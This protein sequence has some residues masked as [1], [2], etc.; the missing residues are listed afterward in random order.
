M[1]RLRLSRD[2][3]A[4]TKSRSNL[5][6][7]EKEAVARLLSPGNG[8]STVTAPV[9]AFPMPFL[10]A[11]LDNPGL[12]PNQRAVVAIQVYGMSGNGTDHDR[13]YQTPVAS[14]AE[15]GAA[16][17]ALGSRHPNCEMFINGRFYPVALGIQFFGDPEEPAS[18]KGILL[19]GVLS[20]CE[21]TFSISRYVSPDLFLDEAGQP[22]ERTV[23]DILDQFGFRRLQTSPAE[24]NVKL[25]RAERAAREVGRVVVVSGPVISSAS[26]WW[27]GFE[28]QS[29]TPPGQPRKGV[30]EPELEVSDEE[31]SYL[32]PFGR[33]R[34]GVT[35]LPFV[36][37]FCLDTKSYVYADV[38]DVTTH[39]F[40]KE[41][42]SRLHLPEETRWVLT[43][44]FATP[45]ESLFG[46]LIRG[47]HGGVVVLACGRPGVGKTLTAEVYAE[48]TGR[49]L[50]VLEMGELGTNVAQVE[51]NLRR[52]FTRVARWGAVLQL[53][54]AEIFLTERGE[55]LERS[56]I[57]GCFLRLLDYYS[58]LL[59]LSTNR[60]E[61]LDRAVLSR[62]ILKINYPDLDQR[63]RA[64]IWRTMLASAGFILTGGTVEEL[65]EAPLNGRQIRNLTRLA[66][67]L[68]PGG[69]VT[70]E[71]MRTALRYGG[72]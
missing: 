54:E 49:P 9:N 30:V 67:I 50:Y 18:R 43:Q 40:D 35:R 70:L 56:A 61:V 60:G 42:M 5:T 16:F 66:K 11:L 3:V 6:D 72:A 12:P 34:Q 41:A 4:R 46:D 45:V 10:K 1:A 52:V 22:Q 17:A 24:F 21:C 15:F 65:A 48:Q 69:R 26:G 20:L 39:E 58:G 37:I 23:V 29:A 62:V 8:K 51:A 32:A 47:K 33:G 57:V 27:P 71:Q 36:R 53:D 31:R 28:L 13:I 14:P 7:D 25:M 68:F 59:F 38:D 2:M 63:A 64:A 55:D 19:Q 44:V